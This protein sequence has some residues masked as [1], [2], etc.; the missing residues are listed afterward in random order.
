MSSIKRFYSLGFI[1]GLIALAGGYYVEYVQGVLPCAL[2]LLQRIV[3]SILMLLFFVGWMIQP[4]SR[5]KTIFNALLLILS[6]TGAGLA[7][8]QVWLQHHPIMAETS[9]CVLGLTYLFKVFPFH[10]A[11][12][13]A[14][15]GSQECGK[16][17]G[18]IFG[19]SLPLWSLITFL[20]LTL[21]MISF[22]LREKVSRSD[23]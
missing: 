8:R 12:W 19:F 20:A 18:K 22:S 7:L 1:I 6:I 11:L 3:L 13:T 10:T 23:G 5:T 9:S 17:Y 21:L 2:C 4:T 14:V 15:K 16:I